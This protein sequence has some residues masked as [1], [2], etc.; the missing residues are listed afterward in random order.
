M[1]RRA[2]LAHKLTLC[3]DARGTFATRPTEAGQ[4]RMRAAI[5]PPKGECAGSDIVIAAPR[6]CRYRRRPPFRAVRE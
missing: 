6:E 5:L 4:P 3:A 2:A 1:E